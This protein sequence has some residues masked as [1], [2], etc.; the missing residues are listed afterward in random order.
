[1]KISNRAIFG[2][3]AIVNGIQ[4]IVFKIRNAQLEARH[5]DDEVK[6]HNR[7][8][9]VQNWLLGKKINS[10]MFEEYSEKKNET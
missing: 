9:I 2:T 1:M 5:F 7:D 4:I 3:L 6:M 8:A 10:Q